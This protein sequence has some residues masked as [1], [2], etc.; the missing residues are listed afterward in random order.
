MRIAFVSDGIYPYFMGGKEKRLH[1]LSTR[2]ARRGHDVH[3]YTMHWWNSPERT[4]REQGVTLHAIMKKRPMYQGDKRDIREALAFGLACLRLMRVRADVVDVDHMP[5]F[6]IFGAWVSHFFYRRPLIGT[7]HEALSKEDWQTYMGNAGMI[8]F[9]IERLSTK[10]PK[11][12]IAASSHTKHNLSRLHHRSRGA[13]VV[14]S[15]IDTAALARIKPATESCDILYVGRLV[16]DKRVDILLKAFVHVLAA[17]PNT[18]L[19]IVGDG[20]E[21]RNL[22]SLTAMLGIADQV[23][24]TGRVS[25]DEDIYRFM[26]RARVF[27][28]ASSR[29]GFGIVTIEAI[30]CGTP[31]VVADSEANAAKDLIEHGVTGSVV[32]ASPEAFAAAC[33]RWLDAAPNP[34]RMAKSARQFDWETL[35]SKLEAHYET[36]G[37]ARA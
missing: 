25:L 31:V 15:G 5:F 22:E 30:A 11:H 1:E 13:M 29:E 36:W 16:K 35:T 21:R 19:V 20:V 24:F 33:M 2:L 4:V 37:A 27:A 12:I 26:K 34:E 3:I 10:L 14:A 17:R 7:W 32:A 23:T 28:S 8:A 9:M 6:P 18:R